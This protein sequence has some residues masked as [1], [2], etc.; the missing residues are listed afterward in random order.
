MCDWTRLWAHGTLSSTTTERAFVG[1]PWRKGDAYASAERRQSDPDSGR[2]AE[3]A[4]VLGTERVILRCLCVISGSRS[5]VCRG[6]CAVA[7]AAAHRR[8]KAA[9]RIIWARPRA[10]ELPR[11]GTARVTAACRDAAGRSY[12]S[13]T[14]SNARPTVTHERPAPPKS[15]AAARRKCPLGRNR[16]AG[17]SNA[18]EHDREDREGQAVRRGA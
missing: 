3:S 12:G 10:S 13:F 2:C 18:L 4:W 17:K 1:R 11:G 9:G 15:S 16:K 14:G 6:R 7:T 8:A 5:I